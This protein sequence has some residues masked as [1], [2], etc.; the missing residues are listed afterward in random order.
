MTRMQSLMATVA[1]TVV[2][3]AVA[4][5]VAGCGDDEPV[6]PTSTY[7]VAA[8]PGLGEAQQQML[9]LIFD[10]HS[11]LLRDQPG[12]AP[13]EWMH[14]Y[15][16][17]PCMEPLTG[18][19]Q[20]LFFPDLVSHTKMTPAQWERAF[21][22]I[23]KAASDAGLTEY[24]SP[25]TTDDFRVV[26]FGSTDGRTLNVVSSNTFTLSATIACRTTDGLVAGPD[27]MVPMPPNP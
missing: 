24:S 2:A 9:D 10:I 13:W 1:T 3:S 19:G 20:E 12:T 8:L 15:T 18:Q 6:F 17:T 26:D 5:T 21:G 4:T 22:I 16:V 11:E 23:E 25:K 27:G 14:T 7:D